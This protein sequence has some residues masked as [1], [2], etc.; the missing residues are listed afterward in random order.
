MIY[1]KNL[2]EAIIIIKNQKE[3]VYVFERKWLIKAFGIVT[4]V[5]K[6]TDS[7]STKQLTQELSGNLQS[8]L[9]IREHKT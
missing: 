5:S 9:C 7:I 3:N 2:N 1:K 8:L 4:E 6:N